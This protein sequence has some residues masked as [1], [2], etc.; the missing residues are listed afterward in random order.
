MS[1]PAPV[2]ACD[3]RYREHVASPDCWCHPYE[4]SPGLW[5]HRLDP[6]VEGYVPDL[7]G[8]IEGDDGP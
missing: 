2:R 6:D 3:R 8:A 7:K 4:D 5:V 1:S